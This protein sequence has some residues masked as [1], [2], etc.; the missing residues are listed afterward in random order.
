MLP[1]LKT[2][3]LEKDGGFKPVDSP[4]VEVVWTPKCASKTT[5]WEPIANPPN[6]SFNEAEECFL[7]SFL[8]TQSIV[9]SLNS[10]ATW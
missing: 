6:F 10:T 2:N 7:I 5:T 9:L 4:Y 8:S 3:P 1:Y